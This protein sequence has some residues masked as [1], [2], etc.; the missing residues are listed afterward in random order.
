MSINERSTHIDSLN[1]YAF[2]LLT[3]DVARA[4]VLATEAFAM[5]ESAHYLRG[6]AES[7]TIQARILYLNGRYDL[8]IQR[9]EEADHLFGLISDP[10]ACYQHPFA[11][12]VQAESF[13]ALSDFE[14]ALNLLSRQLSIAERLGNVD[15]RS[16]ALKNLGRIYSAMDDHTTALRYFQEAAEIATPD[17]LPEL[18]HLGAQEALAMNDLESALDNAKVGL[19]HISFG[20]SRNLAITLNG[21]ISE[22][23]LAM[24]DPVAAREHL[25][26]A[27]QLTREVSRMDTITT[28]QM[29]FGKLYAVEGATTDALEA[30]QRALAF[31]R[32]RRD[33]QRMYQCHEA[34]AALYESTEHYAEALEHH[35]AYANLRKKLLTEQNNQRLQQLDLLLR[36]RIAQ[37]EA[38]FYAERSRRLEEM[39]DQDRQYFEELSN[40]KDEMMRTASHDLKNPLGTVMTLCYLLRQ[41]GDDPAIRESYIARIE[42]QVDRMKDLIAD[43]LDLA[44]LETGRAI[45]LQPHSL[46][47]VILDAMRDIE[48][49]ASA[50]HIKLH[51]DVPEV[52]AQLD[53]PKMRQV[54]DNLLSNAVKYSP[55]GSEV[56]VA[57]MKNHSAVHVTVRDSGFGIPA[58]DLPHVFERFYRVDSNDHRQREGSG[59]G[60]A[61]VKSIVDQHGGTIS[62]ESELGRGTVFRFSVPQVPVELG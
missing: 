37:Q 10:K 30:Y 27:W 59:L 26:R 55:D 43:L 20:H 50:R 5:A 58:E 52:S 18:Y 40:I 23:Y 62:V 12:A 3:S 38:Q 16:Q 36:T 34:L 24:G 17:E 45:E 7:Y 53:P 54:M 9:G 39:R 47:S 42:H 29:L 4:E 11:I 61:I 2:A 6:M 35:K 19:E 48:P 32:S 46:R 56:W 25:D 49:M 44:K 15:A 22:V 51:V 31:A 28:L 8:A 60:L 14:S 41:R 1:A 33:Q 57:V 13:V 21:T